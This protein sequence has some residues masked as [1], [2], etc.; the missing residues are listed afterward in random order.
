MIYGICVKIWM[1]ILLYGTPPRSG[2]RAVSAQEETQRP[3]EELE[4]VHNPFDVHNLSF[5]MVHNLS[6]CT[7]AERCVLEKRAERAEDGPTPS[8]GTGDGARE[9]GV[10]YMNAYIDMHMYMYTY[11]YMY[12]YTHEYMYK[13]EFGRRNN[14]QQLA[15]NDVLFE[16]H[17]FWLTWYL[18]DASARHA[19]AERAE[20]DGRTGDGRMPCGRTRDGAS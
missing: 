15:K 1:H 13:S 16:N 3:A 20:G 11:I 17:R 12:T 14:D 19:S 6:C 2:R 7:T 9:S 8:G 18:L 5:C 10:L 4:M